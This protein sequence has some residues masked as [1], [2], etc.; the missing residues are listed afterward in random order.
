MRELAELLMHIAFTPWASSVPVPRRPSR[1]TW[2]DFTSDYES[3][4]AVALAWSLSSPPSSVV[5]K[6]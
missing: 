1:P 2:Q 4:A 3:N 5:I 6:R